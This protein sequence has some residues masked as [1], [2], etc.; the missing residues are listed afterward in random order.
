MAFMKGGLG[1]GLD[2]IFSENA[3]DSDKLIMVKITDIE[4]NREQPRKK[5]NENL[6]DELAQSI[7]EHGLLQPIIVKPMA[8]GT[9]KIIAG[10]RRWRACRKAGVETVP[11]IIKDYTEQEIMEVALIEN[12]QREDLNPIEEA[13]G[14]KQL[15]DTYEL[16]QEQVAQ[17]VGKSRT[18][19]ANALRLLSLNESDKELLRNGVITTGHA[20]T[21]LSAGSDM[22]LHDELV[23]MA[24]NGKTVR[25]LENAIKAAKA[26]HKRDKNG[27]VFGG[28]YAEVELALAET[29]HRRV[30]VRKI[31]E[32]QGILSIEFYGEEELKEMAARLAGKHGKWY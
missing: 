1:K 12:L 19:V 4:P 6:I 26:R 3:T 5:F 13:Q 2:A 10:E 32:E 23:E 21:L 27:N 28:F 9:Y 14:Y 18:A 29:M 25:D 22:A 17:R 15:M 31:S 30:K 20:R 7:K 24:I 8:N 11:I 16:T